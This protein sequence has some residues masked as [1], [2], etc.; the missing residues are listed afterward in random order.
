[1]K[2]VKDLINEEVKNLKNLL[3]SE[4]ISRIC[5][6]THRNA[7]PDALAS[8]IALSSLV[9]K[10]NS[11]LK[12]YKVFPEGIELISKNLVNELNVDLGNVLISNKDVNYNEL[13][14]LIMVVDT[15]SAS[16]L[17]FLAN[18]IK[19][20]NYIIVDHHDI[21]DLV[22]SS[23]LNIYHHQASST[24]EIVSLM[25]MSL[26]LSVEPKIASLLI[27]GILYDTRF[28][29]VSVTD[30]TFEVLSWLIRLG[31]DYE[32]VVTLLTRKDTPYP[33]KV[34]RLKAAIRAGIYAVDN[35]L[36]TI[37]CIGAYESSALKGMLDL[38]S[39]IAIAIALR[40]EGVRVTLRATK[41]V[42]E[43]MNSLVAAELAKTLSNA[44]GGSGGGHASAAGAFLKTFN[45][46]EFLKVIR[47]YFEDKGYRFRVLDE[48]R[49][50]IECGE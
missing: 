31:G 18:V 24:S 29:R 44:F 32:R 8:T 2:S 47:K 41:R 50:K 27:A 49:W 28:L 34:A 4:N 46:D 48:G 36:L 42:I 20:R 21:N 3:N 23:L 5:I 26:G 45:T 35:Y 1:M 30:V 14:D 9:A 22:R 6:V 15:A 19:S 11:K 12:I 7:D 13:C 16:Q 43:G 38:G 33:E 40:E 39:D 17:A 37:T 25:S 10:L